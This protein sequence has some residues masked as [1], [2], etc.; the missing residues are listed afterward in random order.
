M[1]AS[2]ALRGANTATVHVPVLSDDGNSFE[3]AADIAVNG[4]AVCANPSAQQIAYDEITTGDAESRTIEI[5]NCGDIASTYTAHTSGNGF[6]IDGDA[7][8]TV[9]PGDKAEFTVRFAPKTAGSFRGTLSVASQ[10]ISDI[11]VALSGNAKTSVESVNTPLEENGYSLSV[12]Y[13]NP[14]TSKTSFEFAVPERTSVRVTLLDL[15]G[16]LVKEL[17]NG[18]FESGTHTVM[19]SADGIASGT[20]V[21][22]LEASGVRLA[23]QMVVSK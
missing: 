17:A 8:K 10:Y 13:P 18:T 22:L 12:N 19:L 14:T 15:T 2:P 4:L 6:A 9:A 5:T 23:R 7:A 11:S 21:Y 20:Y 3:L 16:K 1:V